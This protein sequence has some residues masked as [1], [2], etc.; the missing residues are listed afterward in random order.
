MAQTTLEPPE[1]RRADAALTLLFGFGAALYV[2]LEPHMLGKSD[3]GRVLY[4]AKRMLDG[5]VLYLD[6]FEYVS[7]G[8][9][10]LVEA[11]FWLFGVNIVAAKG[12]MAVI[13]GGSAALLYLCGRRAGIRPLIASI[14][15]LAYIALC[16]PTFPYASPHWASSALMIAALLVLLREGCFD[17]KGA[18]FFLGALVGA[19]AGVQHNKG[20]VVGLGIGAIFLLD[21]LARS[22]FGH[23]EDW[24]ELLRRSGALAGGALATS[25]PVYGV[26]IWM[27]G[28]DQVVYGLYEFNLSQYVPTHSAD[29]GLVGPVTYPAEY[30]WLPVLTYAPVIVPI[31]AAA[32]GW[33]FLRGKL[34]DRRS[35]LVITMFGL[36]AVASVVYY[37]DFIH[38]AFIS[39]IV[40]IVWA[41]LAERICARF[42]AHGIWVGFASFAVCF[43]LVIQLGKNQVRFH[44]WYGHSLRTAFGDVEF[45]SAEDVRFVERLVVRIQHSRSRDFF[46]YPAGAALYLLVD[47]DN[48]TPHQYIFPWFN[49]QEQIDQTIERLDSLKVRHVVINR[50][51]AARDDEVFRYVR[52]AYRQVFTTPDHKSYF[53]RKARQR[54]R[55]KRR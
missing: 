42:R 45:H 5:E 41:V 52:G 33:D 6:V 36:I 46:V 51:L 20:A 29:W 10:Y 16:Q 15:P 38:L 2:Y 48:P 30:T 31:A 21:K 24:F 7:P 18:S 34:V 22:G 54:S 47:G 35:L 32:V 23:R 50:R 44:E 53:V 28:L 37:P 8:F 1:R 3:E 14:P 17:R 39:P 43:A 25:I 27:A 40:F 26:A 4:A 19:L 9:N 13:H 11:T 49:T 12:L 55:K